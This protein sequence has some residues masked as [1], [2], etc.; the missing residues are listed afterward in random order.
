VVAKP[1]G[2]VAV[3]ADWTSPSRSLRERSGV[4]TFFSPKGMDKSAQGCAERTT[5]GKVRSTH[6]IPEGDEYTEAFVIYPLQGMGR[7]LYGSPRVAAGPQP[8]AN[9]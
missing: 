5:L 2:G 9:L 6:S 8:W 7:W 4:W 1:P 3:L